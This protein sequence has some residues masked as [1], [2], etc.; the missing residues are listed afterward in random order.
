[1]RES[2]ADRLR[3]LLLIVPYVIQRESVSVKELCERFQVTK[4]QVI[5][6]L[7]LLFVCGLPS[8]GPGDLIEADIVGDEVSI[9]TA[10]YFARPLRL[11]PA[12]GL[13]LYCGAKALEA[14]GVG[15]NVLDRAIKRLEEALGSEFIQRLDIELEGSPELSVV[16]RALAAEKRIHI[17]YHSPYKDE[18]TERDVDP[19]GVFAT[20]GHW[21]VVGW[22]H[23]AQGER[24]FRVDRIRTVAILDEKAD[25]PTDLD[26]S[27]YEALYTP[28]AS[29]TRIILELD[30]KAAAWVGEYYPLESQERLDDGWTRVQLSAR[31]TAWLERLLLRLGSQARV[32]EPKRLEMRVR[33][34]ACQLADL[35]RA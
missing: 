5:A 23:L 20:T 24:V 21:Y 7:H 34:L 15:D 13:L 9:R 22:C 32:L 4:S 16:Q 35:Y 31:G 2:L 28:K 8:Y 10:D 18:S 33:D 29:D 3:R 25:I 30:P 6:D 19:W 11:T 27:V 14:A 12:E 17:N 26:L 1:V